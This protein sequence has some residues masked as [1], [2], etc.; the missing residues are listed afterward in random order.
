VSGKITAT[1]PLPLESSALSAVIA[2]KVRLNDEALS[3]GTFV[4]GELELA[5]GL[6]ELLPQAAASRA[7]HAATAES[8]IVLLALKTNETTSIVRA[9]R[10]CTNRTLRT[11]SA[12]VAL[13]SPQGLMT[14]L[15]VDFR[16]L[17]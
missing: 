8:A 11:Q 15:T 9:R 7:A 16:K 14:R 12:L 10:T 6:D 5:E 1:F 3:W 13:R 2:E 4:L 17:T